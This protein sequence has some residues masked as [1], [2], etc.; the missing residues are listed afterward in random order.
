[1]IISAHI[2]A[3]GVLGEILD[4]PLLAFFAGIVLH[5][6]LD[7]IPHFD[8]FLDGKH[9]WNRKQTIF[10]SIDL[11][12]TVVLLILL[13]PALNFSS[14]FWWGAFG[15]LLPDLIDNVPIVREYLLKF[16]TIQKYHVFHESTHLIRKTNF[17][18]GLFTQAAV[19]TIFVLLNFMLK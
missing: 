12:L 10:T 13:H 14:P 11:L 4:N 5:F 2:V 19:I 9:R 6:I 1:M 18:F 16:K 7:A 3:G 8:N 15:G 17:V